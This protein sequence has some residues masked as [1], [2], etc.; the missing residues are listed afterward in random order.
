[1]ELKAGQHCPLVDMI[2]SRSLSVHLTN[3]PLNLFH[4]QELFLFIV[5][6][7]NV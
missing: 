5:A 1:M 4:K 6:H 7:Y 2:Q 3:K